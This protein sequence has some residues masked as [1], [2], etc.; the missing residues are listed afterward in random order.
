M[1]SNVILLFLLIAGAFAVDLK[2]DVE[3]EQDLEES[4]DFD[5]VEEVYDVDVEMRALKDDMADLDEETLDEM[6][7]FCS[8][9]DHANDII[10]K[11]LGR[12]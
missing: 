3:F 5:T 2:A 10:C 12:K 7:N 4:G 1:A 6:H 8:H 11:T 9:P